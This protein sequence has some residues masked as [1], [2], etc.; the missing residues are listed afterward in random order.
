MSTPLPASPPAGLDA[1]VVGGAVRDALL[2]LPVHDRDWVVVGSTP[3]AMSA[4]GFRPVGRDFPVFLHPG[5]HEEYALARTERKTAPGYRGF[6][7]HCDPDVTLEEDLRRRDLTINAMA[8]AP[9]GALV[10]PCGGERDLRD[11]ILRHVGEAFT[12]DPVRVLRL[13]RFASRFA[14]FTI[15]AETLALVRAMVSAGEVDALVPE[16]VWQEVSRGLGERVPSRMFAVLHE[17]GALARLAPDLD[18]CWDAR[19]A[20]ILDASAAAD[21]PLAVRFAAL[22]H[23]LAPAGLD[24]TCV[25]MRV[26]NDCRDLARLARAERALIRLADALPADATLALFERTD[27]IRKPTRFDALLATGIAIASADGNTAAEHAARAATR[28]ARALVSA[29]A[30]DAGAIA[31]AQAREAS[32]SPL[33]ERI[34]VAVQQARLQALREAIDG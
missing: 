28:L 29:R 32:P 12:E 5:T 20:A 26:P 6:V 4:L 30:V 31:E 2:G 21:A 23:R 22:A 19:L 34:R 13:A 24:A 15:A 16:R 3:D 17:T 18:A 1:Y 7:V 9:A 27:A 14:G 11:G 25:R 33:P 10:D 8:R